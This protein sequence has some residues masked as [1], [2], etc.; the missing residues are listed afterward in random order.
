[1]CYDDLQ[2]EITT[3]SLVGKLDDSGC[4]WVG[5][6]V[7][8]EDLLNY[9]GRYGGQSA[10]MVGMVLVV[11]APAGGAIAWPPVRT[12]PRVLRDYGPVVV[13]VVAEAPGP[14]ALDGLLLVLAKYFGVAAGRVPGGLVE[15]L[16]TPPA[17]DWDPGD[18]GELATLIWQAMGYMLPPPHGPAAG[19]MTAQQLLDPLWGPPQV[20]DIAL[21]DPV[22]IG[23]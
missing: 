17:T 10:D 8:G 9:Y 18:G 1:M 22:E 5:V 4:G 11:F 19:Q 20:C 3:G 12:L 23:N 7:R 13:R 2:D 14:E 6:T 16:L 15:D 21:E